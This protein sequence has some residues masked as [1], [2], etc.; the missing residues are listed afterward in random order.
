[1]KIFLTS[2]KFDGIEYTGPNIFAQ[3]WEIAK[4]IAESQGLKIDGELEAIHSE[5]FLNESTEKVGKDFLQEL[6]KER[7][8]H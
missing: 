8:L 4:A 5:D 1:M 2:F 3:N 6:N 7:V